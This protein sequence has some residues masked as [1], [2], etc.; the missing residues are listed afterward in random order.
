MTQ[1]TENVGRTDVEHDKV[2]EELKQL[3]EFKKQIE[4]TKKDG[5]ELIKD[6]IRDYCDGY[7]TLFEENIH[8]FDEDFIIDRYMANYDHRKIVKEYAKLHKNIA[9]QIFNVTSLRPFISNDNFEILTSD[10]FV[11]DEI[12]QLL[13]T[14]KDFT[15]HYSFYDI[16]YY[17]NKK[18]I[19]GCVDWSCENKQYVEFIQ[20]LI[21]I[22]GDKYITD[23]KYSKYNKKLDDDD[24]DKLLGSNIKYKFLSHRHD[25]DFA[26]HL[27][28]LH[29]TKEFYDRIF[30]PELTNDCVSQYIAYHQPHIWEYVGFYDLSLCCVMWERGKFDIETAKKM[31]EKIKRINDRVI[32]GIIYN[33]PEIV[34]FNG[35]ICASETKNLVKKIMDDIN[36]RK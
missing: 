13:C 23:D 15:N 20:Q 11:D 26:K 31:I 35:N 29:F 16:R 7:D 10:V 9:L 6:K 34:E 17:D 24:Y 30:Y 14:C 1:N 27:N 21:Y 18:V 22:D 2:L 4:N 19:K 5:I 3:R 36:E 33:I 8:K 28:K 32:F 12:I 25:L